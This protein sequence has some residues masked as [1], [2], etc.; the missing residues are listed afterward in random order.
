MDEARAAITESLRLNPR[1][2]IS[3]S[4]RVLPYKN[5]ADLERELN[6]LRKLG[7]PE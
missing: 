4:K 3:W 5:P 7:V 2:T 1:S 6:T